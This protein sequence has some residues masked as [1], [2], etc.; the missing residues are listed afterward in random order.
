MS[1]PKL[2]ID[3]DGCAADFY[4]FVTDNLGINFS[5]NHKEAWKRIEQVPNFFYHLPKIE[6]FQEVFDF[7]YEHFDCSILTALPLL[8]VKLTT[9]AKDKT[10]WVHEHLH[11]D[12][13]V[14]CTQG[15]RGKRTYA[16]EGII[17]LDDM[18]RNIEDWE[19]AGGIGLHHTSN[20]RSLEILQRIVAEN[21]S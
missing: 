20:A 5:N 11:P 10:R 6:G 4:S 9:A 14:I 2:F 19:D 12:V 8:T 13:E 21:N 7:A 16:G 1:K 17:L 18:R 15:W 3:L